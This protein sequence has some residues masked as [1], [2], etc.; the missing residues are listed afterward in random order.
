MSALTKIIKVISYYTFT[1]SFNGFQ[2][3]YI[4]STMVYT[5]EKYWTLYNHSEF[6]KD[7]ILESIWLQKLKPNCNVRITKSWR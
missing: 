5:N 1:T 7:V 4:E 6:N 2:N 3:F